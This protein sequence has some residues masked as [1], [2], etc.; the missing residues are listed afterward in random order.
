MNIVNFTDFRNN[1]KV[2]LDKVSEDKDVVIIS[3][4]KD[5]NVVILPLSEYNSLIETIHLM[6]TEKNRNRIDEALQ[7]MAKGEFLNNALI[8]N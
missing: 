8:E 2:N 4:S 3:R 7:E 1:L 5:K 6:Q